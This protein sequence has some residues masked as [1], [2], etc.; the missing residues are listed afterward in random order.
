MISDKFYV[1]AL[2]RSRTTWM[3][4]LLSLYVDYVA[5]DYI[6]L[7]NKKAGEVSSV[8]T[9]GVD[10]SGFR[11]AVILRNPIEACNSFKNKFNI[12]DDSLEEKFIREY[13]KLSSLDNCFKIRYEEMSNSR[14]VS[15][16]IKCLSGQYVPVNIIEDIQNMRVEPIKCENISSHPCF[17]E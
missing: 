1:L 16:M 7:F 6:T 13:K 12:A 14:K 3:A 17:K 4:N 8:E 2:P 11:T 15:N 9:W 5:H 10:T